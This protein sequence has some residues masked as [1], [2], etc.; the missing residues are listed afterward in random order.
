MRRSEG[1]L[2]GHLAE[3]LIDEAA[4]SAR[5][6]TGHMILSPPLYFLCL[7]VLQFPGDLGDPTMSHGK[8]GV[9]AWPSKHRVGGG[10]QRRGAPP[11]REQ[12]FSRRSASHH[13]SFPV[14]AQLPNNVLTPPPPFPAPAAPSSNLGS[15]SCHPHPPSN[16]SRWDDQLCLASFKFSYFISS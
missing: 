15:A 8:Q 13:C 2:R 6:W 11:E 16:S 4:A 3:E 1:L 9:G 12:L 14:Q 7:S 5:S 10:G